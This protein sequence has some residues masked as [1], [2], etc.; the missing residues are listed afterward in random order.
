MWF[1]RCLC[2]RTVAHRQLVRRGSN[3]GSRCQ[4][5]NKE[6]VPQGT[7]LLS[8]RGRT[9]RWYN[10]LNSAMQSNGRKSSPH[11]GQFQETYI[12]WARITRIQ[13]ACYSQSW[14]QRHRACQTVW[15][16]CG[17][18]TQDIAQVVASENASKRWADVR[19]TLC[20]KT[21][22]WFCDVLIPL[23]TFDTSFVHFVIFC[24]YSMLWFLMFFG[25]LNI[26]GSN[27]GRPLTS[28]NRPAWPGR[29]IKPF[30]GRPLSQMS[31]CTT[32]TVQDRWYQWLNLDYNDN[33]RS[34]EFFAFLFHHCSYLF[35]FAPFGPSHLASF[36]NED[37]GWLYV[38]VENPP[39]VRVCQGTSTKPAQAQL[40]AM[41]V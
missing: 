15:G 34:Q 35:L 23:D 12:A 19:W 30:A 10:A 36:A 31:D 22:L 14:S 29:H 28:R 32:R 41:E 38:S 40:A 17:V 11:R 3:P 6:S 24:S 37:V 27:H 16:S 25:S 20:I 13:I 4:S 18:P 5:L 39:L 8:E 21:S 26:F 7:R 9:K 2:D 33:R 1:A